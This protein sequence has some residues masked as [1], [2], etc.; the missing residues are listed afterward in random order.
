MTISGGPC[1][2]ASDYCE[3][4]GLKVPELGEGTREKLR[5]YIPY[6]AADSNPVDMT[7]GIPLENIGPCVDTVMSDPDISGV[8]A[9]NWGWDV[10]EFADAFVDGSKRHKKPVLAFASE[11]PMVQDV[12][13][14]GGIVN[15]P[16]P[17]RAVKAY[18]G[19]LQYGKVT[20]RK[21]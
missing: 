8:I 1:V 10:K 6:F 14:Q 5:E 3:E 7:V 17:E 4:I 20:D 9:I 13:R 12:F 15:F 2:A 19:L 11:N 21:L 18:W 16:A